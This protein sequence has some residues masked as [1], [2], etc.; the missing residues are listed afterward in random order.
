MSN[1]RKLNFPKKFQK[2]NL[3]AEWFNFTG[4]YKV[5]PFDQILD[6]ALLIF[7]ESFPLQPNYIAVFCHGQQSKTDHKIHSDIIYNESNKK[8][9]PIPFG[10]TYEL[11]D[12]V[13]TWH[14]W[15]MQNAEK[16]FPFSSNDEKR[17]DRF[18]KLNG[19]HFGERSRYGP[20]ED[21]EI[22]ESTE[23]VGPTLV[24]TDIPHSVTYYNPN[25]I[26][27]AF[28]LRFKNQFKNWG[29]VID[30]FQSHSYLN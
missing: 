26:R 22:I 29:E 4:G 27:L 14:W 20:L 18:K 19:I 9:E 2:E 12:T 17:P 23:I 3:P 25:R 7:L 21:S 5:F 10:I 6:K 8:W 16:C 24:R 15:N 1:F 11:S 30:F 28:S 13:S